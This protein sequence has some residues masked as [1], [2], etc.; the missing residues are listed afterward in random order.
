MARAAREADERLAGGGVEIKHVASLSD[1][2]MRVAEA[3]G[4]PK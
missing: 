2:A 3:G 4:G 1:Y